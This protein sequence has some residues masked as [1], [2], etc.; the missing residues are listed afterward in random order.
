MQ[1]S[2][3]FGALIET[4]LKGLEAAQKDQTKGVSFLDWQRGVN[5]VSPKLPA[6]SEIHLAMHYAFKQDKYYSTKDWAMYS[7]VPLEDY[8]LMSEWM[9][10]THHGFKLNDK[11]IIETDTAP[12]LNFKKQIEL[13]LQPFNGELT[14]DMKQFEK[15]YAEFGP[16]FLDGEKIEQVIFAS[17]PRSGNTWLRKLL[18]VITGII[19]GSDE[20]PFM[21]LL[22]MSQT[23][24]GFRG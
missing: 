11:F 23:I 6:P 12:T 13:L 8:K 21:A 3:P 18:E 5:E 16:M 19:T 24:P 4:V 10:T 14:D 1:K 7:A 20:N 22:V 17:F 15:N 2:D 9:A